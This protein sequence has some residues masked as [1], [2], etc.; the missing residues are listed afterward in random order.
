MLSQL[1]YAPIFRTTQI[2]Y[3]LF[4][5]LSRVFSHFFRFFI[6]NLHGILSRA[7]N[8]GFSDFDK[9]FRAVR[10]VHMTVLCNKKHIFDTA[11]VPT[12]D[13]NAGFACDNVSAYELLFG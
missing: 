8:L 1:S 7:D 3:H 5:F 9:V 4:F 11:A 2:L 10:E 6:K 13:V 12:R